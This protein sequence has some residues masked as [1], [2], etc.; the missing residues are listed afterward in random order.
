MRSKLNM[1]GGGLGPGPIHKRQSP[2]YR[3]Y[4]ARAL[5]KGGSGLCTEGAGEHNRGGDRV[6]TF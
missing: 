3:G 5:T 4:G 6:A 1:S 2:L